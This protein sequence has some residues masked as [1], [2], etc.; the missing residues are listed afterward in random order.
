VIL[1]TLSADNSDDILDSINSIVIAGEG[2]ASF[3]AN[4]VAVEFQ[5]IG[6]KN[7]LDISVSG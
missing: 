4:G 3:D 7:W 5:S 6:G 2:S 1:D